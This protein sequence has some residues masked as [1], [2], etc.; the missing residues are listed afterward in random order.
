M[1]YNPSMSKK[2][3]HLG[4]PEGYQKYF[5]RKLLSNEPMKLTQELALLRTWF[6]FGAEILTINASTSVNQFFELLEEGLKNTLMRRLELDEQDIDALVQSFKIDNYKLLQTTV[7]K[8]DVTPK[9]IKELSDV[10]ST[11]AKTADTMKRIEDGITLKVEIDSNVLL[12]FTKNVI[13]PVIKD[14]ESLKELEQ[15][16]R[17][18]VGGMDRMRSGYG[19]LA[20][21]ADQTQGIVLSE[22]HQP[23]IDEVVD[24]YE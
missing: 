22:L 2:E 16:M 17:K 7:P 3:K 5:E 14:P 13:Y 12:N 15:R 23:A 21:A 9:M 4:V 19:L 20:D 11:V 1:R 6:A 8:Y 24:D 18:F 10:L